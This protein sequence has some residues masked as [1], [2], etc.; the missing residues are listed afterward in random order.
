LH[1]SIL[2]MIAISV[3]SW[4]VYSREDLDMLITAVRGLDALVA[5]AGRR[6][7]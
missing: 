4:V 5:A 7:F 1:Q 6:P 2:S 3:A